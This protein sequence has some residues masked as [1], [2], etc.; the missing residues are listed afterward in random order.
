MIEDRSARACLVFGWSLVAAFMLLGL[1]LELFH[2]VKAP[3]YLDLRLRRELWTLAHTHGTLLGLV[4]IGF[5]LTA[6]RCLAEVDARRQS[7]RTLRIG[8]LLMPFG[9]L[10][11][12]VGNTEED[13][14]LFIVLV[15][16]GAFLVIHATGSLALGAWRRRGEN[17]PEAEPKAE[18]RPAGKRK[19]R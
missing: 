3:F 6:E 10:L 16:I 14:S 2:L 5:A 19:K 1:T 18:K 7:S 9:F 11:G 12:G 8:S 4:N 15:P 17:G 13:P